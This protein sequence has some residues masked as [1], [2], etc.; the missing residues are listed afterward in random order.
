[1]HSTRS[2]KL[3]IPIAVLTAAILA[4]NGPFAAATPQPAATL[5]ALYTAAAQTLAGMSTQAVATQFSPTPTLSLPVTA[6]PTVM[7]T[8]TSVP[9]LTSAPVSRCDAAAFVSDVTYP[10]GANVTLGGTFTKIWRL[11]N[12]GTCTWTTSYAL[13]YVSGERFGAPGAVAMPTSVGPG[14]TV[15]L[16]VNLT[17][18]NQG[19]HYRGFWKLRNASNVLFGIGT[20]AASNFFVDINVT[21]YA[22]TAY[23]FVANNNFCDDASWSN[24]S[25]DLHC[26][27]SDGDN[28]GFV[29]AL[30]SPKLEDGKS[31]GQGLLTFPEQKSDGFISGKYEAIKIQS[32]DRFQ[33]LIGCE[34]KANDCDVVFRLQYQ[35]GSGGI[36]TLGQWREVYEGQYYPVN[37]DLSTLSGEKVKFIFT[38]FAN[39]SS[40]EDHAMWV[41]PRITRQSSNPA[42]STPTPT[43]TPTPAVPTV[44]TQA[45]TNIT[46]TTAT[47]NGNITALGIPNPTQHGVVW[48]TSA[49]PTTADNKTTDGPVSAT[50]AFTSSITGLTPGTLYHVRAYATNAAGTAYGEDV[51]FTAT[52]YQLPTVTTQ[53]VTNITTTTARGNGNV[54]TLGVPNPTQHGVVWSTSINPAIDDPA[55]NK[56]TNGA[57]SATGA[58]T[59]TITGLTPGTLYHVR[60]YV[61]NAAGTAYGED[62]TF[63]AYQLPAV[64]TISP[65]TDFTATTA[66][67]NG[68]ITALGVPNPTQHGVVWSTEANPSIDDPADNRTTDGP[69]TAIG[70]FTSTMTVL[71]SGT[72]YYVRTYATNEAGTAYGAELTFLMP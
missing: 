69:V 6:S 10:D 20:D 25:R 43:K 24:A 51:T 21:G 38:V 49:N 13:V 17:A 58:F 35:V 48:S 32:G 59:S 70:P 16:A 68:T 46:S 56:T 7:N 50:G 1:M 37:I 34:Y 52:A 47:G 54:T 66:T 22:V 42:T 44:T 55:D 3:L 19:G 39:G 67:V 27:G 45:V 30:D 53:A 5:D 61:T 64:T 62:V 18:P 23:D 29:M 11:K 41:N 9:P 31:Q 40:H 63:T 26:P 12:I 14:Q 65:V 57:V 28:R 2:K 4:C 36:R 60:A 71:T 8:Y 33:T 72:T 15:D